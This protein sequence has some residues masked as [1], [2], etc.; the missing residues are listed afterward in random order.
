VHAIADALGDLGIR[1]IG[2][3]A[4]AARAA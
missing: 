4:P 3:P 2:K 1:D